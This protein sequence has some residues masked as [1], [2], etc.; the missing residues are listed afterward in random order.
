MFR[1]IFL[2]QLQDNLELILT[3]QFAHCE[4][5]IINASKRNNAKNIS[6]KEKS[7]VFRCF[8]AVLVSIDNPFIHFYKSRDT[9]FV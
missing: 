3:G 8:I 2:L 1:E 4:S 7:S 6:T 5:F 9:R